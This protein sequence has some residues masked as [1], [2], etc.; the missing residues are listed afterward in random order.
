MLTPMRPN[1]AD[2]RSARHSARE[3]SDESRGRF[4]NRHCGARRGRSCV[5]PK[6]PT[7]PTGDPRHGSLRTSAPNTAAWVRR[8]MPSFDSRFDT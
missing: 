4:H 6:G 2:S 1:A 7:L 5:G 3:S 8:S